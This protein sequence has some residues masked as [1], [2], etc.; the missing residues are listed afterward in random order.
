MNKK[1]LTLII[2]LVICVI[3]I[4]IYITFG[5]PFISGYEQTKNGSLGLVEI[6]S[7]YTLS[8]Q[9]NGQ[10]T[11]INRWDGKDNLDTFP[12]KIDFD[13]IRVIDGGTFVDKFSVFHLFNWG[14]DIILVD[15]ADP[16]SYKPFG[17]CSSFEQDR[18][19]YYGDTYNIYYAGK[20]IENSDA[21]TF[22]IL[23]STYSSLSSKSIAVDN[24]NV[25]LGCEVNKIADPKT[26][27]Y[28][29]GGYA[30]DKN[31]VWTGFGELL[32]ADVITFSY[33][34]TN[35]IGKDKNNRYCGLCICNTE[36]QEQRCYEIP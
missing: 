7:I 22:K 32:G 2:L 6:N 27:K 36:Q 18:A 15:G 12:Y 34:D 33:D 11:F 13:S 21:K 23:G 3:G 14:F 5:R 35:N 31:K 10:V 17:I 8:K 16:S 26:I 24:N 30:S 9:E 19:S 20:K 1:F 28:L 29:G 25:Y 4:I